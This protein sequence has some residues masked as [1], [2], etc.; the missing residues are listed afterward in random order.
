VEE[1]PKPL[2]WRTAI[3]LLRERTGWSV[4]YAEDELRKALPKIRHAY[5]YSADPVLLVYDDGM[6]DMHRRPYA[7]NRGGVSPDGRLAPRTTKDPS[8]LSTADF[9]YWLDHEHP[10]KPAP[11]QPEPAVKPQKQAT[12]G[13]PQRDIIKEALK[14]VFPPDGE[15]D[16]K[17]PPHI[18]LQRVKRWLTDNGYEDVPVTRR[19]L[20]RALGRGK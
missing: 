9:I 16:S 7:I 13:Q 10:A 4:G 14:E 18:V 15:P 5:N 19:T 11:Q 3:A 8:H 2:P 1:L 17:L 6:L 12:R 20:N